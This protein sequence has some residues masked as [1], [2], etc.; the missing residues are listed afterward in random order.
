MAEYLI[1][2]ET[3]TGIAD[4]IRGKTGGT[5]PVAVSDMAAAIRAIQA[6]GSTP[7][8]PVGHK[9]V[10][11]YD[12][13]GTLVA[14]YTLEEAQALNVLPN[15]PAHDGLVF[16]GWNWSLED[17]KAMTRPVNVGAMY[18]TDDGKTRLH[19]RVW[20]KARSNVPLYFSQTIASGVTIDWGDGSAAET[21]AGTGNVNTAHQYAA[22]GDYTISLAVADGCTLGLGHASF[23]Y[24]IMGSTGNAGRVYCNLLQVVNIG[25]NVTSIGDSAFESCSSLASITIPDGVTSIGDSAFASCSSLASITIPDG[26]TSIGSYAFES[27]YSLAS[28][29][30]P[31]GVTSIGE[32]AFAYCYSL[33]SITIPDGVTSI[34]DS[35]FDSCYSLASITIPDG[36]TSIISYAFNS[37]Y[38]M[39]EYHLKPT[40]P[41]ALANTN[42]FNGISSD[43][44]IYVPKGSL[45]DYQSATNWATYADYMREED[46]AA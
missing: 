34:G 40:T 45:E 46:V 43:C 30:I 24:C 22:A 26:V 27:C 38:G 39:A 23:G 44:I 16:R 37:C 36:V 28:I 17:V 13:D 1:Q 2:G 21:L 20:D 19:I 3:L 41:P 31:D 12:Y 25:A 10:N 4:A 35:A 7:A 9:N 6:G 11:F 5:D 32:A 29:T 42:A 15:G 14:S 33:A 8:A 18:I